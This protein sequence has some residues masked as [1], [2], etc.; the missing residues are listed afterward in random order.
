MP[1]YVTAACGAVTEARSRISERTLRCPWDSTV[2]MFPPPELAKSGATRHHI[3][4]NH[5]SSE[6]R[7]RIRRAR[8]GQST[9]M[10]PARRECAS[11]RSFGAQTSIAGIDRQGVSLKNLTATDCDR[12]I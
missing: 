11:A 10:Q 4:T 7:I 2:A 9:A 8:G 1:E 6:C 5:E 12:R 3:N